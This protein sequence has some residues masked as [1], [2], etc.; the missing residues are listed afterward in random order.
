MVQLGRQ[1]AAQSN[2]SPNPVQT[3]GPFRQDGDMTERQ[4]T[5]TDGVVILTPFSV[6][7]TDALVDANSDP[8]MAK[9]FDFPP[10]PPSASAACRAIRRWQHGWRT[11]RLIA[12]AVRTADAGRLIGGCELRIDPTAI[13]NVS[14]FTVPARRGEGIALRAVNLLS[15]FALDHLAVQRLEIKADADNVASQH[16]AQRAGFT[17]EGVLRA[18]GAYRKGRRNM[19]LYSRIRGE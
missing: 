17:R 13:A 16:V 1:P 7:D 14:Y 11:R 6:R 8:E 15:R 19:I 4:P 12:F 18:A 5:L 10:E 3:G 2:P 9:R